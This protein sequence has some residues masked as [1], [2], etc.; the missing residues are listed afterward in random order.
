MDFLDRLKEFLQANVTLNTPIVFG[1]LDSATSSIAIRQTPSSVLNRYSDQ[2]KTF[3]FSFQVLVKDINHKKAYDT[4]QAIFEA[5]DGLSNN[6]ITSADG[7]FVFINC[8]C[9]TL[10]NFVEKTT[11]NEYIYSSIFKA[12]LEKGGL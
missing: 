2:G 1:I 5:L 9:Y 6:A 7:S 10:P 11:H 12:E 8:E 4:I 3:E